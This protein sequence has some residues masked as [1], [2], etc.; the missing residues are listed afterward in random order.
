[1]VPAERTI[2]MTRATR[3]NTI[4]ALAVGLTSLAVPSVS[5]GE[6]CHIANAGFYFE[7]NGTGVLVDAVMER[8]DYDQT[9]ALPSAPLLA[10][11]TTGSDKF[12]NV[13]LALATHKHGDHFDAA[14]SLRHLRATEVRYIVPPEAFDL[15]KTAGMT[16]AEAERVHAFLPEWGKGPEKISGEGFE[17]EVYRVDHGPNMPQNLGYKVTLG[18]RTFFH[19]GDI[20]ATAERLA[21]AGLNKLKIDYMMMPFWYA[22]Q[23]KPNVEAAWDIGTMIATHYHAKEQPW[24]AQ[25]GGPEGLRS[26]AKS[27][28]PNSLRIDKEMQCEPIG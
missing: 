18:D 7:N 9:F 14:A 3:K 19:T 24:M 21:D 6:I 16:D 15:M 11:M 10:S 2:M 27:V 1:M 25:S 8:D 13:R 26:A 5:A 22:L 28:W 12:G 4:A 20:N 17:V 23:A